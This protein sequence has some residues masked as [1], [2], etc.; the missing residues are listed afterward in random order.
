MAKQP[1]HMPAWDRPLRLPDSVRIL[2][3]E[4]AFA[5]AGETSDWVLRFELAQ[6]IAPEQILKLQMLGHRNNKGA[7][8]GGDLAIRTAGGTALDIEP[9]EREGI[10]SVGVPDAG[11]PAG[12]GLEVSLSGVRA[13]SARIL[14]KFFVLYHPVED[15]K[16]MHPNSVSA[17][18][19]NVEN[20]HMIVGACRMH[21]LGGPIHHLRAYAPSQAAPGDTVQILV[22][23]E[24]E[25]N[26]LSSQFA[27]EVTVHLDGEELP[28]RTAR[29]PDSTC[30]RV[31]VQL[32]C[33]G[34]HRLTVRDG[35]TGLEATTNPI[36]CAASAPAQRVL[37][38]MIH[39]HTEMSDGTGTLEYYFRQMRD[40]A[41]LDFAA[42]SDHDHLWETW[43][44]V[45][46]QTCDTVARWNHDGR[47]VALLGYEWAKWRRNGD[48]D[49]N[50]YYRH[51]HRPMY[52][53][54]DGQYPSPPDLFRALQGET[55]I[56]IPHHPGHAG[57]FCDWKDHDPICERL[58]EIYQ[59]RG[60]Y[61][62]SEEDGNPVPERAADPPVAD[63]YVRRALAMGW[64]AGFTAG[65]DDHHGHAGTDF[66]GANGY[67]AGL[68]A[69]EAEELSREALWQALW[70][71]RV[72]ATTGARM[73]LSF[74]LNG[75]P[76]GSE[77]SAQSQPELAASRRLEVAFHGTA[78]LERIEV[79]RS[80]Q[81][82]HTVAGNGAD[83]EFTWEDATPLGAACL[84]SAPFCDHPFCFYYVRATQGD[85]EVA[86]AS[87]IW[88]DP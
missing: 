14:N 38:G 50:V 21:V 85:G 23:P 7:F 16:G 71:R 52:R 2:P 49:R 15:T 78:D 25:G 74:R 63:G 48:G 26:S 13:P 67:K 72:V 17:A 32:P 33:E 86:W 4:P 80:N 56:V 54:D 84:P 27:G 47:F 68:M 8:V 42:T 64:R 18:V 37:W 60:S 12:A 61:E 30:V 87:P 9:G 41:G 31:Q 58:I 69:V 46:R 24:D 79:I 53:S 10:Y 81:V 6:A 57:N 11:L 19:W 77:L 22:R 59:I 29:V 39:G 82:V 45:W 62:C 28:G 66:A 3:A 40:E 70:A 1:E 36:R 83:L 43:D 35:R 88:I 34:V 73:L 75:H 51:D 44:A 65:G 76:M 5:I 55:A 20:R